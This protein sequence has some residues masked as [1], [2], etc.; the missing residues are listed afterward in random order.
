MT[1]RSILFILPAMTVMVNAQRLT[2]MTINQ[3]APVVQTNEIIIN[4]APDK[5][6]EVLTNI[7]KWSEWNDRIKSPKL[8][9]E[10]INGSLF[11]WKT[12]G[13]KIKSKIHSLSTNTALGWSGKTFGASAIHN[14]YLESI[15]NGT[16]V[17]VE[18]SMEGWLVNLIKKK[19]NKKLAEDMKYWLEQLKEESE[20]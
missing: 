5:V 10:L 11:T 12:N 17:S 19:M 9:G 13:S 15:E 8:K 7:D 1:Q 16:K 3:E 20:K 18:E 6:W 2:S 4:A 14:W